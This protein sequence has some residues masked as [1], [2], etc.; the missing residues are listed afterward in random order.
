MTS[1]DPRSDLHRLN[2]GTAPGAGA[3]DVDELKEL[4]EG[5]PDTPQ[6]IE[7]IRRADETYQKVAA[8][9]IAER[10]A[11]LL[12]EAMKEEGDPRPYVDGY[13]RHAAWL[14]PR[15][16]GLPAAPSEA[17]LEAAL[18]E[19]APT[20]RA[21]YR[22]AVIATLKAAY[23]VDRGG[24]VKEETMSAIQVCTECGGNIVAPAYPED[25]AYAVSPM[26]DCEGQQPNPR[27]VP[28]DA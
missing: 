3:P 6:R 15:L 13:A 7:T 23:V 19:W 22:A 25:G 20:E 12:L 16:V 4:R 2:S 8:P 11:E 28:F 24:A 1:G 10:L 18:Q 9:L 17:A 5:T 21:E 14:L 27:L 26:C